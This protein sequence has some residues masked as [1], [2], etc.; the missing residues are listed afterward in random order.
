MNNDGDSLAEPQWDALDRV[1]DALVDGRQP[2]DTDSI[3]PE[4]LRLLQQLRDAAEL[5]QKFQST[6]KQQQQKNEPTHEARIAAAYPVE[7]DRRRGLILGDYELLSPIA[8]GGMGIVYRA[9]QISLEREV[10]VKLIRSGLFASPEEVIRFQSE[11]MSAAQLSHAG[12]VSVYSVGESDGLHY[13]A[14]ELVQ[15]IS[16]AQVL[17][18]RVTS[19]R[20]AAAWIREIAEAVSYA[21]QNGR[22]HRDLKPAN[23]LIDEHSRLKVTDFGLSS[24]CRIEECFQS[25]GAA[26]SSITREL[27]QLTRS[28]EILGTPAYMS[29]EQIIGDRSG[30]GPAV[31]VYALGVILYELLTG[32]P[33]F[34]ASSTL[35]TLRQVVETEPVSPR[36]INPAVS[37]DLAVICLKCLEKRPHDRMESA[38]ALVEECDRFLAGKPVR[39]RPI[40]SA[41]RF[42]RLCRRNPTTTVLGL[43]IA[44]LLLAFASAGWITAGKLAVANHAAEAAEERAVDNARAALQQRSVALLTID[45]MI[46]QIDEELSR[47]SDLLPLRQ[48]LL[49]DM[50]KRL[51][52]VLEVDKNIDRDASVARAHTRL[53]HL[54]WLSGDVDAAR[55]ELNTA[56]HIVDQPE[57]KDDRNAQACLAYVLDELGNQHQMQHQLD[58]A[59]IK[60]R[61]SLDLLLALMSTGDNPRDRENASFAYSRLG[62][63]AYLKGDHAAAEH[64][65]GDAV[66][67]MAP[68]LD[69]AGKNR[70]LLRLATRCR[71]RLSWALAGLKKLQ[72]ADDEL[73]EALR[74]NAM[75]I[76]EDPHDQQAIS[77][78][79]GLLVSRSSLSAQ[80]NDLAGALSA[81]QESVQ[82]GD[83][84]LSRDSGN[85]ELR[86]SQALRLNHVAETLKLHGRFEE[87]AAAYV[88]AYDML[89]GVLVTSDSPPAK[90]RQSL[91][92]AALSSVQIQMRVGNRDAIHLWSQRLIEAVKELGES[93]ADAAT[94]K[95]ALDVANDLDQSLPGF[96][97]TWQATDK[98]DELPE[99]ARAIGLCVA[100]YQQLR[101]GDLAR[102]EEYLLKA[103]ADKPIDPVKAYLHQ[104]YLAVCWGLAAELQ[105]DKDDRRAQHDRAVEHALTAIRSSLT[106]N[107]AAREEFLQVPELKTMRSRQSDW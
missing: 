25:D 39:T 24:A 106:I 33:P 103:E 75:L 70:R 87:A 37:R 18:Q 66:D 95:I 54:M 27:Q 61:R 71:E 60:Y 102:A 34:S 69:G 105:M 56:I 7:I 84:L 90:F 1:W 96:N 22:I 23:I 20:Q 62:D 11:A 4:D 81:A 100:A 44:L 6:K 35:E 76:H 2:D 59:Q 46:E 43:S 26:P 28:G 83:D 3:A 47:R 63:I 17:R 55:G 5:H 57:M 80:V 14:M 31:D 32:R 65:Y 41:T 58:E 94:W 97:E 89:Q 79:C 50:R 38:R 49:Q 82:I 92:G 74:F 9:R 21:H 88:R 104:S 73:R 45:S 72:A 107:P 52:G 10:A 93:P 51:K 78:R 77:D 40:S 16:L 48:D 12:I 99:T 30:I 8:Q 13:Y 42:L 15:G 64:A 19:D 101:A 36:L 91:A 53:A 29:P 86:W 68:L 67:N 85:V 98:L